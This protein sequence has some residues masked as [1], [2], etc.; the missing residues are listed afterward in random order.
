[1]HVR[2]LFHSS[3]TLPF[4]ENA[5]DRH[6]NS[7]II[8]LLKCYAVSIVLTPRFLQGRSQSFATPFCIPAELGNDLPGSCRRTIF[9]PAFLGISSTTLTS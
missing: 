1:M 7:C 8:I 3:L 2:T 6:H 5:M 4:S 9:P